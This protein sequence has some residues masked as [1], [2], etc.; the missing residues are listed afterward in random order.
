VQQGKLRALGVTTTRR[1]EQLPDVPT[2]SESGVP[3]YDASIWLALLAPAGTPG[4]IIARY[5]AELAKGLATPDSIKTLYDAGVSPGVLSP[6]ETADLM[7]KD[8]LRWSKVIR[9]LGIKPD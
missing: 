9:E 6:Q 2:L 8:M 1:I 3:G 7:N 4:E 5:H